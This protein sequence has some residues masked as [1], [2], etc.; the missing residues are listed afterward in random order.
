[1]HRESS[2]QKRRVQIIRKNRHLRT[3][4]LILVAG[5][6]SKPIRTPFLCSQHTGNALEYSKGQKRCIGLEMMSDNQSEENVIGVR[7]VTC[8]GCWKHHSFS[9]IVDPAP[10]SPETFKI[11]TPE[12]AETLAE[13]SPFHWALPSPSTGNSVTSL[14][15]RS[16]TLTVASPETF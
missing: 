13:L 12:G 6:D 3:G 15:D 10:F 16:N 4:I 8:S 2:P 14:P 7:S 1:M 5:A 9:T 11:Y